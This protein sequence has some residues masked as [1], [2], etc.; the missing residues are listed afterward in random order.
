MFIVEPVL[1]ALQRFHDQVRVCGKLNEVP[2]NV[3]RLPLSILFMNRG[4]RSR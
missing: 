4:E 1:D 3:Q 2:Q